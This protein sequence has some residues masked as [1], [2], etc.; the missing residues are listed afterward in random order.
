MKVV[1]RYMQKKGSTLA[2]VLIVLG[3]FILLSNLGDWFGGFLS[4]LLPFV[5]IALGYYGI[6]AGNSFFGW[7]F[8]IIGAFSLIG[9][10]SWLIGI[11]FAVGL[12]VWGV[13]MLSGKKRSYPNY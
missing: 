10:F 9:K 13:S 1:K 2:I 7:V 6:K 4:Y 3:G 5:M 8:L 11:I 12:I